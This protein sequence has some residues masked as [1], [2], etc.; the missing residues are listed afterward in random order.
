VAATQLASATPAP[1]VK[2]P[3]V[4]QVVAP[5][6]PAPRGAAA[7]AREAAAHQRGRTRPAD[8][9]AATPGVPLSSIVSGIRP[10]GPALPTPAAAQQPVAGGYPEALELGAELGSPPL[11][12]LSS[13]GLYNLSEVF[14][15]AAHR[16]S[17]REMMLPGQLRT[18]QY[19]SVPPGALTLFRTEAGV[20]VVQHLAPCVGY[21]SA[22]VPPGQLGFPEVQ[23]LQEAVEALTPPAA[24][25]DMTRMDFESELGPSRVGTSAAI[26]AP[27]SSAGSIRPTQAAGGSAPETAGRS[28]ADP[29][30]MDTSG[31]TRS[32]MSGID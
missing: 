2:T 23:L 28:T 25:S 17:R 14:R 3:Y 5:R 11:P 8:P 29:E 10:L 6:G 18:V 30:S 24:I 19:F 21:T 32:R 22:R 9:R 15:E 16:V 27:A 12:P 31:D 7:R 20:R 4:Q 1:Q 13:R 26:D